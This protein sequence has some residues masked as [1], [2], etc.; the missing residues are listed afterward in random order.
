MADEDEQDI[1]KCEKCGW[2]IINGWH[3]GA[4]VK[5]TETAAEE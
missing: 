5:A 2:W 3:W 4:R 1:K